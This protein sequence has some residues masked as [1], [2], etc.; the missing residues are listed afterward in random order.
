MLLVMALLFER[1]TRVSRMVAAVQLCVNFAN[2]FDFIFSPDFKRGETVDGFI[3]TSHDVALAIHTGRE[4]KLF[5]YERRR[6]ECVGE[7]ACRSR[8]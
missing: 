5:P 2:N 4:M 8:S 6:G 1:L 3:Q 7:M